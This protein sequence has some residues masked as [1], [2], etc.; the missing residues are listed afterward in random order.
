MS[1]L[2]LPI[3]VEA[4]A[5]VCVVVVVV[6]V[7][8]RGC[9][10]MRVRACVCWGGGKKFL[11]ALIPYHFVLCLFWND[12]HYFGSCSLNNLTLVDKNILA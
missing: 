10:G 1:T 7:C 2:P 8:M 12:S 9:C 3:K 5:C 6:W 4:C 11:K